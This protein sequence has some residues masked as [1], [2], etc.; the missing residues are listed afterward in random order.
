MSTAVVE[1]A[2]RHTVTL[3]AAEEVRYRCQA[4]ELAQASSPLAWWDFRH[5]VRDIR[6]GNI[7]LFTAIVDCVRTVLVQAFNALQHWRGGREYP[8]FRG[9]LTKTPKGSLDLRPGEEVQVK[10]KEE[11]RQTLDTTNRNRGLFF[12]SEM[13]PYCGR[14][15][16]VLRRVRKII[17]ENTGAMMQLPNDC[18]IL[19]G[20]ICS[21]QD[22]QYC[23]R[24]IY[25]YW[26][27][28]WLRRASSDSN[29][30]QSTQRNA[31]S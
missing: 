28:L 13:L 10:S 7:G 17:N 27:E 20:V 21:G 4:T 8:L 30:I 31:V 29:V 16:T 11:I 19:D 26:R 2:T 12:S 23:P 9:T 24:S 5:Y 14:T 3:A 22:H 18:V 15:F 1:K 25:P 6:S